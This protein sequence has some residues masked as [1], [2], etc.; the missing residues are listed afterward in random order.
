[1]T[2][3]GLVLGAI[4]D[5][6]TDG[7]LLLAIPIAM[8]AGLVSFLSPCVLPLVP[9]YLGFVTGM[10]ASELAAPAGTDDAGARRTRVLVGALGFVLGISVVFISFGALFGAFGQVLRAN[11]DL[12]IRVFGVLTIVLGLA[13]A[14]VFGNVALFN[15]E[16]RVQRSLPRSGLLAAPLLGIAFALGWTPCIGPTLAA[17]LGLAA[18]S[19]QASAARGALLSVA[20]CLGLGIP[21]L[22]TGLAFSR[23]MRAFGWVKRHYRAVMVTGGGML[24]MMGV[25]QVTG[26]WTELMA[27]LQTRF[28]GVPLPL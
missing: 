2:E 4:G 13:L 24:V 15:R 20:Y 18:S 25:F 10:S 11:E 21:F 16:F 22:V 6:V 14:G 26:V 19:D 8:L 7:S 1:M 9:G 27:Y 12:L 28:G 5:P 23:A 3:L 17:V